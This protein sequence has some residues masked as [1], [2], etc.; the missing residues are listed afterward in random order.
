MG[1]RGQNSE[2]DVRTDEFGGY[3]KPWHNS[4]DQ[5]VAVDG[6]DGRGEIL[7]PQQIKTALK[8]N[9][10]SAEKEADFETISES[11]KLEIDKLALELI[12][13]PSPA[14]TRQ[15]VKQI[16]ASAVFNASKS[17]MIKNSTTFTQIKSQRPGWEYG[18]TLKRTVNLSS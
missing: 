1:Y 4:E 6:K 3:S 17:G 5:T 7:T 15:I 11:L 10:M 16:T 18:R 9:Q 2:S 8:L 14:G 12:G 13:R